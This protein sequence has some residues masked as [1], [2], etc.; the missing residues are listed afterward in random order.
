M[1]STFPLHARIAH[2]PLTCVNLPLWSWSS[3]FI[4][5]TSRSKDFCRGL[6][7][8]RSL[9]K[10]ALYLN[11]VIVPSSVTQEPEARHWT[12]TSPSIS[13]GLANFSR[14]TEG[15]VLKPWVMP[16]L[17]WLPTGSNTT[18]FIVDATFKEMTFKKRST[19]GCLWQFSGD[20]DNKSVQSF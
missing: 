17:C 16:G 6:R 8:D 3:P 7:S 20:N 5:A 10:A 19:K 18:L 1:Q 14:L 11:E 13:T 12:M 2:S 15:S 4:T 9:S